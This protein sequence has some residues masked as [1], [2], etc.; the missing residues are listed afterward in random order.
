MLYLVST[1]IGNLADLSYRA[2][3]TLNTCDY[4]LCEDTRHSR[5]LLKHYSIDKPLV[6]YHQHNEKA[7]TE[8]VIVDLQAGKRI[9]LLSDA[10][11]PLIADPGQHLLAACH[12]HS[13]PI[14]P[15]PGPCAAITALVAAGLSASRFQFMGFLPRTEGS[16]QAWLQ[17]ALSYPGTTIFYESPHRLVK[18]LK[19]LATLAPT[20]EAAVARELTKHY[21]EILRMPATELLA[22]YDAHPPKGEIVLLVEGG[23]KAQEAVAHQLSAAEEV[24]LLQQQGHTLSAAIKEVAAKRQLNKRRL[25]QELHNQ[26]AAD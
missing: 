9:A 16:R 3:T 21:E 14:C 8:Q 4:L 22:H 15:L 23:K 11:T 17:E 7:R 2:V 18:T 24:A 6:S 1:P 13:I 25:Y 26:H 5:I 20:A 10:G 19:T 12:L